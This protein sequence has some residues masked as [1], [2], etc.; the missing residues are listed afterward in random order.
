M[1]Y[2]VL[3]YNIALCHVEKHVDI[4]H[5]ISRKNKFSN[6]RNNKEL[7]CQLLYFNYGST[8]AHI[9]YHFCITCCVIYKNGILMD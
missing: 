5:F 7:T 1:S 9:V 4:P 6:M 3:T 2:C 8:T